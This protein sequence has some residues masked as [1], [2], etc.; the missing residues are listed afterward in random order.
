MQSQE[1]SG[2]DK[3][4]S[5]LTSLTQAVLEQPSLMEFKPCPYFPVDLEYPIARFERDERNK[6]TQIP[7]L[8]LY[9]A[10]SCIPFTHMA[11]SMACCVGWTKKRREG[12]CCRSFYLLLG[13]PVV[14]WK[15]SAPSHSADSP[16]SSAAKSTSMMP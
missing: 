16:N 5:Q 9:H 7:E 13:R 15:K 10:A 6:S 14:C 2:V 1:F 4:G 8:E 12:R 11:F 3:F